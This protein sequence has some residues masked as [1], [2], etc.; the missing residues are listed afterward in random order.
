MLMVELIN[1]AKISASQR[2]KEERTQLLIDAHILD[3]TGQHY[4]EKYFSQDTV[5]KSK[6]KTS[7]NTLY[8]PTKE[9]V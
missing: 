6:E 9:R 1:K 4:D 3:S 5:E 2:S 7:N 8:K